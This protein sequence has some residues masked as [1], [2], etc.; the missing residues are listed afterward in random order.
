MSTTYSDRVHRDES[1]YIKKQH[2]SRCVVLALN[3]STV[4]KPKLRHVT[5]TE[6][7]T[8]IVRAT[9]RCIFSC[10]LEM[11]GVSVWPDNWCR[12]AVCQLLKRYHHWG[13]H[14]S[15]WMLSQSHVAAACQSV[16]WGRQRLQPNDLAAHCTITQTDRQIDR[17]NDRLTGTG[18]AQSKYFTITNDNGNMT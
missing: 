13:H 10:T 18:L 2:N 17:Q 8:D 1:S 15:M 12:R 9:V 7:H 16:M 14:W 4:T 3:P 6:I 5:C 11:L